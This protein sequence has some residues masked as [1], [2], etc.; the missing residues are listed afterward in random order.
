MAQ[1]Q[2]AAESVRFERWFEVEVVQPDGG[3][4]GSEAG[5]AAAVL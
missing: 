5:V 2:A 4:P 1:E 3:L